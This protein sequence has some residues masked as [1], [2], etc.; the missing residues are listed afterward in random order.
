[1]LTRRDALRLSLGTV[2]AGLLAGLTGCGSER[3]RPSATSG[4]S[5]GSS[6]LKIVAGGS[7]VGIAA[8][9]IP[10]LQRAAEENGATVEFRAM[11]QS[12]AQIAMLNGDIDMGFMSFLNLSAAAEQNKEVVGVAPSWASHTSLLVRKDSPYQSVEDLRGKRIG[13]LKR[14]VSVYTESFAVFKDQGYEFEKDFK[15]VVVD[16]GGLLEGLLMQNE[17]D[18]V[19]NYEPNV[20]RMLHEGSAREL[21]QVAEYWADQGHG[22][23]PAQNWAVRRQFAEENDLKRIQGIA[24]RA[25]EIARTD[26]SL[27]AAASEGV[28]ISDEKGLDLLFERFSKLVLPSYTAENLKAAQTELDTA[29]E[30]GLTGQKHDIND[31]VVQA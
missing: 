28:N 9:M 5:N 17:V 21:F 13:T 18:A 29:A 1:M 4:G 24:L 16:S 20:A 27:Y 23:A 19:T 7:D 22:V 10:A 8:L 30:A 25:S 2:G 15:V 12:T 26:R 31:L 3:E 11:A 6:A 14:T